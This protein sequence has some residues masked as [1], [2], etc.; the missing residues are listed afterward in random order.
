[1]IDSRV[2]RRTSNRDSTII[3][4]SS[5]TDVS[6]RERGETAS[7]G[8]KEEREDGETKMVVVLRGCVR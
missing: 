6:C 3:S 4:T 1:M 7:G 8:R 5:C 2:C